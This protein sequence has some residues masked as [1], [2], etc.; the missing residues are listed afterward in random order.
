ME[1]DISS[2]IRHKTLG[3]KE[4]IDNYDKLEKLR[5]EK[6]LDSH[7]FLYYVTYCARYIQS[8]DPYEY[9]MVIETIPSMEEKMD[10]V[11]TLYEKVKGLIEETINSIHKKKILQK[12]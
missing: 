3:Y 1:K 4:F 2:H 5:K 8:L 10:I 6:I 9:Q 7:M 11:K 12:D